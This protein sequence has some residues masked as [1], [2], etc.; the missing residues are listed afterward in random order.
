[1]QA[2][3]GNVRLSAVDEDSDQ[4]CSGSHCGCILADEMGLG[5]T[6]QVL[7]TSWAMMC[8][9]GPAGRP[10][11]RK[12]LVVAPSRYTVTSSLAGR[13]PSTMSAEIR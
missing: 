5:K 9:G 10:L 6:V 13:L 8:G 2:L 12:M 7:A 11:V 4:E 1:M 3:S